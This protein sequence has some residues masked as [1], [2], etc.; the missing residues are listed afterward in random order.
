MRLPE[1]PFEKIEIVIIRSL[2]ILLLLILAFKLGTTARLTFSAGEISRRVFQAI[3]EC[4]VAVKWFSYERFDLPPPVASLRAH[5]RESSRGRRVS[6]GSE[7]A[8]LSYTNALD[9]ARATR[10]DAREEW[11]ECVRRQGGSRVGPSQLPPCVG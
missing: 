9:Y 3:S 7:R 1:D 2:S 11:A 6:H 8:G 5:D 4:E 10:N